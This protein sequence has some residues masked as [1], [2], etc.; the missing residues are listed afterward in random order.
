MSVTVQR[1]MH[2]LIASLFS[3][4]PENMAGFAR[5]STLVLMGNIMTAL[6]YVY[7]LGKQILQAAIDAHSRSLATMSHSER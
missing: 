5:L 4:A 3:A 1:K 2:S 7:T 6:W